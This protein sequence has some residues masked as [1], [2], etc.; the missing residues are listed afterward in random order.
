MQDVQAVEVPPPLPSPGEVAPGDLLTVGLQQFRTRLT[1]LT[2]LAGAGLVIR[3]VNLS[4][5]RPAVVCYLTAERPASLEQLPDDMAEVERG[6]ARLTRARRRAAAAGRR[7]S[8]A[9]LARM[10]DLARDM[11]ASRVAAR[12]Q[13]NGGHDGRDPGGEP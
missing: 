5:R 11:T 13:R 2:E 6:S 4:R 1:E 10:Q 3:V 8:P 7:Y 9:G 12:A